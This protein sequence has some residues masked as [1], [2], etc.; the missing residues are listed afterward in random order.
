MG[1]EAYK[2]QLGP[3]R[4]LKGLMM[5]WH[6]GLSNSSWPDRVPKTAVKEAYKNQLGPDRALKGSMM[7]WNRGL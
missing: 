7:D 3:D 1:T 2:N 6:R 4:A 5:D